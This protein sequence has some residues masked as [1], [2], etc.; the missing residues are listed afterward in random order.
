VVAGGEC[1]GQAGGAAAED[2]QVVI[3][4]DSLRC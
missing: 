2:D 1:S 4:L 3:H